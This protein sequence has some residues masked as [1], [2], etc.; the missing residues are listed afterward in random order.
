[1]SRSARENASSF[2]AAALVRS[3][4]SKAALRR[5]AYQRSRSLR[6]SALIAASLLYSRGCCAAGAGMAAGSAM[7]SFFHAAKIVQATSGCGKEEAFAAV[8]ESVASGA[9][10]RKLAEIVSAQGG[11]GKEVYGAFPLAEGRHI[12]RAAEEGYVQM[13]ALALGRACAALGGGRA[14]EGDTIDHT[15]GILLKKR[16]G[17]LVQKGEPLAE[18][19]HNGNAEEGIALAESAFCVSDKKIK[20]RPLVYAF[21]GGERR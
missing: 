21:F 9:A 1:M 5:A 15:V 4:C 13:S 7:P 6:A 11:D 10:L 19:C 2:C 18:V 3:A 20:C 16:E 17:S 12:I 14:R 8:R